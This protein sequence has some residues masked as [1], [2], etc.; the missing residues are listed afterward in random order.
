MF[1][2]AS[3]STPASGD[4]QPSDCDEGH[5]REAG[6]S[7]GTLCLREATLSYPV[8]GLGSLFR[9]FSSF[10]LPS[11]AFKL[12]FPTLHIRTNWI[13]S[14]GWGPPRYTVH[15]AFCILSLKPRCRRPFYSPRSIFYFTFK[16]ATHRY[17]K[18]TSTNPTDASQLVEPPSRPTL[19]LFYDMRFTSD[20]LSA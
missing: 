11:E 3:G 8:V 18:H 4:R 7:R 14:A 10:F 13:L 2:L 15:A 17:W 1:P 19:L 16:T 20:D 9:T 6:R 12:I 5:S